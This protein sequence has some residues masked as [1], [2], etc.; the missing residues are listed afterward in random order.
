MCSLCKDWAISHIAAQFPWVFLGALTGSLIFRFLKARKFDVD[1][2][3]QMWVEMLQWRKEF[4]ADT[5]IEV[6]MSLLSF[7]RTFDYF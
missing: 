5:I 4:G 3:K 2:A 1:K 6:N 7:G